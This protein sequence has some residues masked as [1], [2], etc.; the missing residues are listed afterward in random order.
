M[1]RFKDF[2]DALVYRR[3]PLATAEKMAPESA[4]DSRLDDLLDL[5]D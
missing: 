3:S 2:Y 1:G 5:T 4:F